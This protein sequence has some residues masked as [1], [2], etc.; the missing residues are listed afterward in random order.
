MLLLVTYDDLTSS[1]VCTQAVAVATC[2]LQRGLPRKGIRLDCYHWSVLTAGLLHRA[3]TSLTH[4]FVPPRYRS[5][6]RVCV[7]TPSWVTTIPPLV[8]ARLSLLG[9]AVKTVAVSLPAKPPSIH[10]C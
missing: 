7:L 1:W 4:W 9:V 8:L 6:L 2:E 3:R 5:S 10:P